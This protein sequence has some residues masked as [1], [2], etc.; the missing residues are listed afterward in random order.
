MVDLEDPNGSSATKTRSATESTWS[1]TTGSKKSETTTEKIS[2]T[3]ESSAALPAVA[4]KSVDETNSAAA[5]FVT[6]PLILAL[7]CLL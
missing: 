1:E 2:T 6:L 5:Y 7:P 4:A 3:T